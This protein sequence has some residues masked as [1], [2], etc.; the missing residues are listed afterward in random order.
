MMK[1]FFKHSVSLSGPLN[2]SNDI[3]SETVV[4]V[5]INTRC[6]NQK[7]QMC[8]YSFLWREREKKKASYREGI[9]DV[10]F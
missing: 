6:E 10:W 1:F 3:F 9:T 5:Y 4:Q 7:E 8:K 2:D